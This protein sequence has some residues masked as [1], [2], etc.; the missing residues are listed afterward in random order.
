MDAGQWY[1]LCLAC[2]K[3]WRLI[4]STATVACTE[5]AC[6]PSTWEVQTRGRKVQGHPQLHNKLH[7][8]RKRKERRACAVVNR[9]ER[10]ILFFFSNKKKKKKQSPVKSFLGMVL[11]T[12]MCVWEG[13]RIESVGL[14]Y[15]CF[16][17][18]FKLT[19]P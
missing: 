16:P 18:P 1:S 15:H 19:L 4:P 14:E 3:P 9:A 7:E 13:I 8:E 2:R 6:D 17:L 12:H 10:L 5:H 11:T